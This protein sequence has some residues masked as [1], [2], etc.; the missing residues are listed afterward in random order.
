VRYLAPPNY[1][2]GPGGGPRSAL[3]ERVY[4]RDGSRVRDLAAA[5]PMAI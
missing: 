2:R 5:P 3:Y 1:T 4:G